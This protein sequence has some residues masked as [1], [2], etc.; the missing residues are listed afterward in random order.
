M[1]YPGATGDAEVVGGGFSSNRLFLIL[2]FGFLLGQRHK[3]DEMHVLVNWS[4]DLAW[5]LQSGNAGILAT[6]VSGPHMSQ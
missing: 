2:G 3:P 5:E 6:S 1:R 4:T